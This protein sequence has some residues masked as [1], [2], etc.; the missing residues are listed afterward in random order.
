MR[1]LTT[2][3]R[4]MGGFG[5]AVLL[6]LLIGG[7][8]WMSIRGVEE[9]LHETTNEIL[10]QVRA[11]LGLKEAKT[12][13]ARAVNGLLVPYA[14]AATRRAVRGEMP[15]LW[16]NVEKHLRDYDEAPRRADEEQPWKELKE[17]FQEWRRRIEAFVAVVDERDALQLRGKLDEAAVGAIDGRL[18]TGYADARASFAPLDAAIEALLS[19]TEA[20]ADEAKRD[21]EEYAARGRLQFAIVLLVGTA[22]LLGGA[23]FLARRTR[24][25]I[26]ALLEESSRLRDAVAAGRLSVRGETAKIDPEF[27]GI[28]QGMN[29]TMDAFTK[30]I[31]LTSD[32]VTRISNGEIPPKI[33]DRYEGDFNQIKD[34]LNRCVDAV[35]LLVSDA[36]ALARA[37][38]EGRLATRADASRH[39]GDFRRIVQGVN[40][41]LDAVVGP[42]GVAAKYVDDIAKGSLPPRITADWG[43]DFNRL[44]ENLHTCIDSLSGLIAQTARMSAEHEKG[45]LD[46]V[47]DEKRFQG[48]YQQMAR[49]VNEMVGAHIAVNRKAMAVFAEFGRGNFEAKIEKLPGKK[50]FIHET[51]EQVRENL[52]ALIA[53]ANGLADAAVAGKLHHRADASRHHGDFRKIVDGVNRTLDAVIAPVNEAAEVLETLARRD[54]RA[55]VKGVYQGDHARIQQAVNATADA[56]HQALAQVA[57][58][59]DQV[60]TAATQIASSSQ[61]VASGASEQ[62]SSL[63]ETSSSIESVAAMVKSSAENAAQANTLS[64]S[65]RTAATEGAA[66]VEQMQGAMGRI[67]QSAEGTSLIIKDINDIAF[68]TNLLALNAAVEAARAG[69]AGRGFAVVA[70]EVRSLAL[71]AKEAATKTEELIRDSVSQAAEGEVSARHVGGKLGEIVQGVEKVTA[72][73]SEIAAAAREQT[74]AVEQVNKAISEMDKVTQHNA[75]SAEESSSTASEL[76]A[77]AE[78][79]A[80]M[81]GSFQLEGA[82]ARRASV[83]APRPAPALAPAP[84]AKNGRNGHAAQVLVSTAEQLFPMESEGDLRDF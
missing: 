10:P 71:R 64:S 58:A 13:V 84:P 74:V 83:A 24:G 75:A 19:H 29:E 5:L 33:A 59:V 81:V 38:V 35:N 16:A 8:A 48:A 14:D 66:A 50:A 25:T 32:F 17:R 82:A 41:T 44:K 40:E 23:V 28:V 65:A 36:T 78:E 76:S 55:R 60:S 7:S 37:G 54:L 80:A 56:L 34:A 22:L 9:H 2:G 70:E 79:L 47:V 6:L 69:E 77:Q 43:G 21:G 63:T 15:A 51:V 11:L 30:P 57:S 72:I 27:R 46:V 26:Q 12:A 1:N 62:A 52:R 67:K 53:D 61:S 4:L 68:Q 49:G 45:D 31:R 20:E 42:L 39:Q 73:V 3:Q 18:L